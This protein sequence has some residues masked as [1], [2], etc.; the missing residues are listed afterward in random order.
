[1]FTCNTNKKEHDLKQTKKRTGFKEFQ[2]IKE[3]TTLVE[4]RTLY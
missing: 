1:M 3:K 4:I 2:R